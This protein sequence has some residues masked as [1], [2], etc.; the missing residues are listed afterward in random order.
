MAVPGA[1]ESVAVPGGSC[2]S[3]AVSWSCKSMAVPGAFES[4]AVSGAVNRQYPELRIRGS[5]RSCK[6]V[7][8]GVAVNVHAESAK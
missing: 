2:E 5:T 1:F 6:S 8:V 7:A 4:V 3:V